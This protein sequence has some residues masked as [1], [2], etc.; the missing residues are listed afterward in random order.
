MTLGRVQCQSR[1]RNAFVTALDPARPVI[2]HTSAFH[3]LN[4]LR[5]LFPEGSMGIA[6]K[7]ANQKTGRRFDDFLGEIARSR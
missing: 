3:G 6:K 4:P 7:S 1:E 5:I 2:S